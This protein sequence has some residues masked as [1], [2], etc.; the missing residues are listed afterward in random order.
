MQWYK[1]REKGKS[2]ENGRE[3]FMTE[4]RKEELR[5]KGEDLVNRVKELIHQGNIRRIVIKNSKGRTY[6][7]IPLTFG[8]VGAML[9]PIWIT[10][11]AIAALAA[12]FRIEVVKDVDEAGS[13]SG[14]ASAEEQGPQI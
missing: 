6:L 5:V 8:V 12:D 1:I 10:V 13:W 2:K 14:T 3:H 7:E 11:G 9:A 4:E